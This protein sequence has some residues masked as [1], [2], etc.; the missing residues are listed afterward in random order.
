M[1]FKTKVKIFR[2]KLNAAPLLDVIFLLLIFFLIST[3]YDFQPGLEVNL[4]QMDAP[5]VAGDKLIVVIAS[6]GVDQEDQIPLVFFNNEQV[7]WADLEV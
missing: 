5:L 2:G 4:P 3:S 7:E 6:K 1:R